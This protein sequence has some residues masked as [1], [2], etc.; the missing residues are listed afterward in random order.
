MSN[1]KAQIL[2]N[3]RDPTSRASLKRKLGLYP[4]EWKKVNKA[5]N[6]LM[7]EG[8]LIPVGAKKD[9]AGRYKEYKLYT[10]A[11]APPFAPEQYPVGLPVWTGKFKTTPE[12]HAIVKFLKKMLR[13]DPNNPAENPG[14]RVPNFKKKFDY[15]H[16]L[17]SKRADRKFN[18]SYQ[19]IQNEVGGVVKLVNFR[20]RME[21]PLVSK[22]NT[23]LW[24]HKGRVETGDTYADRMKSRRA[25]CREDNK[26]YDTKTKKC[27]PRKSPRRR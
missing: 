22:K 18:V 11:T 17:N 27:R 25:I 10:G 21:I 7:K 8:K 5:I 16:W 15:S 6:E 13:L 2:I 24:K 26:V 19:D 1:W 23:K 14:A 12:N 4:S 20:G 3:S 9:Y